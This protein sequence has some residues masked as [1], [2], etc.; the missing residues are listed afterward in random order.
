MIVTILAIVAALA[1]ACGDSDDAAT[2]AGT[3]EATSEGTDADGTNADGSEGPSVATT[4]STDASA[5]ESTATTATTVGEQ[6]TLSE[7][8]AS[9]MVDAD[10][11]AG[12]AMVEATFA[13]PGADSLSLLVEGGEQLT[14]GSEIVVLLPAQLDLNG[15]AGTSA[16]LNA[17]RSAIRVDAVT[18]AGSEVTADWPAQGAALTFDG[19]DAQLSALLEVAGQDGIDDYLTEIAIWALT[20]DIEQPEI[21]VVESSPG[22][23]GFEFPGKDGRDMTEAEGDQVRELLIQ[24]RRHAPELFTP[25]TVVIHPD[26]PVLGDEKLLDALETMLNE[27]GILDRFFGTGAQVITRR[28]LTSEADLIED[29]TRPELGVSEAR[30][31]LEAVADAELTMLMRGPDQDTG[32]LASL[33][34]DVLGRAGGRPIPTVSGLAQLVD[35]MAKGNYEVVLF[36]PTGTFAER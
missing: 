10:F 6:V 18:T 21:E 9:G 29:T 4:L 19:L 14:T 30:S 13:V 20:Q 36:R 7:A 26:H 15:A 34:S 5:S 17:L 28:T 35:N 32:R 23:P 16:E 11:V 24:T 22:R 2:N 31:A 8:L 25:F 33:A 27:S 1:A 12:A 3:T